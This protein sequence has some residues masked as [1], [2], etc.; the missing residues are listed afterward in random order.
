[1]QAADPRAG[2]AEA[3]SRLI[4]RLPI[5]VA[6]SQEVLLA[7]R[8]AQQRPVQRLMSFH[9][10]QQLFLARSAAWEVVHAL[11]APCRAQ[12]IL[13][14]GSRGPPRAALELTQPVQHCAPD[15]VVREREEGQ[16]SL[17]LEA[18]SGIDQAESPV[19][20]EL[21]QLD[22]APQAE[23]LAS[24]EHANVMEM[25]IHQVTP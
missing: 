18:P 25:S 10:E 3:R 24:R 12:P 21:V 1:M 14:A 6:G 15:A 16:S 17:T 13:G 22:L 9:A 7:H 20:N 19:G 23:S 5:E 2:Q 4:E 8:Q 11:G